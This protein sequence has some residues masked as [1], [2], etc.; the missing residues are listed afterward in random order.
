MFQSERG[1]ERD[2][3]TLPLPLV[4]NTSTVC[5]GQHPRR[6]VLERTNSRSYRRAV[7]GGWGLGP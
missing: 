6:N 3:K 5:Q 4:V 7:G 2:S 1:L